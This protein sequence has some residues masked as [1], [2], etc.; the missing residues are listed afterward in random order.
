MTPYYMIFGRAVYLFSAPSIVQMQGQININRI[1]NKKEPQTA[2]F[3]FFVRG[4]FF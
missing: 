1:P 4:R 3:Y 2:P